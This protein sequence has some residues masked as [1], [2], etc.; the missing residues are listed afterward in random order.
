[1]N[2]RFCRQFGIGYYIADFY[3]PSIKL[4]IEID[5]DN[6]YSKFG[7]EYDEERDSFMK[8]LNIVVLRIPNLEVINRIEN[9]VE[10]IS[11]NV[12]K[13]K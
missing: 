7:R 8:S 9:V 1:M 3:A 2:T 13:L 11:K 6:H 5:G 10:K 4:V 12:M